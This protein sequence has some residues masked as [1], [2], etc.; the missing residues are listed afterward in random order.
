M[1]E[2]DRA[3]LEYIIKFKQING[4]SPTRQD[5]KR[6]LNTKSNSWIEECLNRLEDE[7]FIEKVSRRGIIV[8]NFDY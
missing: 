2:G 3:L 6:G 7:G 5:M 1:R 4:C 8:V